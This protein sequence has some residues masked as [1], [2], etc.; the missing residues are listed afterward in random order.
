MASDLIS[1]KR[2][3]NDLGR[4]WG[5]PADWDGGIDETCEDA[6]TVI[7]NQPTV[8]AVEVVR[9]EKCK[10]WKDKMYA[11]PLKGF[12]EIHEFCTENDEFC[13][14]GAKMDGGDE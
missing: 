4:V 10:Y 5:I 8:D 3:L 13:N 9:C 12:C 7:E 1:R 11:E 14:W 6:F 2:L